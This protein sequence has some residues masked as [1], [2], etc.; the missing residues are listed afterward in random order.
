MSELNEAFEE[1]LNKLK[2]TIINLLKEINGAD[3]YPLWLSRIRGNL[4][5]LYCTYMAIRAYVE[6]DINDICI[7]CVLNLE[8]GCISEM[9]NELSKARMD[10]DHLEERFYDRIWGLFGIISEIWPEVEDNMRTFFNTRDLQLSQYG[11]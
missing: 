10:G 9:I 5:Q 1:P 8:T 6:K 2:L 3:T 7:Q 4:N 11:L